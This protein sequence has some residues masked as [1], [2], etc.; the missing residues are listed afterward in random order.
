M[1]QESRQFADGHWFESSATEV[2][3]VIDPVS[4]QV[5]AVVPQGTA[6]DVDVAVQA[7]ARAFPRWSLSSVDERVEIFRR[8]AR[9]VEAR[10]DEITDVMVSEVGY[11]RHL[12]RVSQTQGAVEELEI[13]ADCLPLIRF[14]EPVGHSTLRR[15]PSGVVGAITAW[16]AP[17]RSIVSK[18]GAAIAAGCTVVIKPAEVAPQMGYT[19]AEIATEAGLPPGVV[20]VVQG[21]GPVV[22]EAIAGH[23]LVDVVSLTGS[24]RAGQRVMEVASHSIKRVHLELGGK[25][26]NIILR[27]ADLERAITVGL[28][29]AF[30]NGGQV[31]GGLTRVLVPVEE[32]E[33][34][35]Q[36]AARKANEFVPGDPWDDRT[37]LA[38]VSSAVQRDRVREYIRL[39]LQEGARLI[40]GG[41]EAPEGL[42]RGFFVRPTVFQ[43]TNSMRIA[44][45]EI[46]GPVVVVIPYTDEDDAVSQAND[47]LYG[48]AGA[49]WAADADHARAVASRLRTGRVRINGAP[50]DKRATH[51]GFK[52]SGVGREWGHVGIEEFLEYQ[53]VIG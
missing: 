23:A 31:C 26:A 7:A 44:Q 48:L 12:A 22:G 15:V 8:M 9:L 45:E 43:G 36:I 33:H 28:E 30:R 47:S 20:N 2:I 6:G 39:G 10:A 5:V 46:F 3:E 53:S 19:F 52:L 13:I 40:V 50:L 17:L 14:E 34:A 37:T 32:L 42:S 4:E 51:G 35:L 24:V 16:N 21:T 38:P 27:G 11:P 41:A 25:S 49:V 1:R 18:A 29:D